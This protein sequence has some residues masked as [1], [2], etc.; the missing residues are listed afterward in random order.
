MS[1]RENLTF[2]E[3]WSSAGASN[4][5][6]AV[7]TSEEQARRNLDYEHLATKAKINEIVGAIVSSEAEPS[8]VPD[9]N[10]IPTTGYV[11]E[12]VSESIVQSDWN[13]TDTDAPDYIKNKPNIPSEVTIDTQIS[14][15]STN[16]VQN[17]AIYQALLNMVYPV[18]SIYMSVNS[19]S[20]AS[21]LGGTWERIQDKFLLAAGSSHGAGETGGAETAALSQHKH[22]YDNIYIEPATIQKNPSGEWLLV[23]DAGA[24]GGELSQKS[25]GQTRN[26]GTGTDPISTMPP[27]LAVYMWKRVS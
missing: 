6:P 7:A 10:H 24:S 2:G 25:N 22:K 14:A 1:L 9:D 8:H 26:E 12:V 23:Y 17:R 18:G 15:S 16:P 11:D 3:A 20:P 27:Y 19:A 21:F 5:F 4:T 13:Q